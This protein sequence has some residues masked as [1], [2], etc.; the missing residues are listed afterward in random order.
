MK[1]L[2]KAFTLT[3]LFIG[4]TASADELVL[5]VRHAT[6]TQDY[7]AVLSHDGS[8]CVQI[9]PASSVQVRDSGVIIESPLL[10]Q[11][12][13]ILVPP[14]TPVEVTAYIGEL[15][16]GNYTVTWSQPEA[17]SLS[18]AME[19][20]W[21]PC[22]GCDSLTQAPYP[23]TGSWYN[24]DQ[25]GSGLVL[26]I[27]NGVLAGSYYGYDINGLPEWYL[28]NGP[29]V[30]SEQAG[31][32]WELET[33]LQSFK[34]GNCIGC[35]YM[36]PTGPEVGAAI[37]LEIQQRNFMR[38]TIGDNPSQYFVPIMYGSNGYAYFSEQTPYVFPEYGGGSSSLDTTYFM[39][40]TK[41]NTDPPSPWL[42]E[43]YIMPI[44][45]GRLSDQGKLTY[46]TFIPQGP[47]GPDVFPS[48]IECELDQTSYQPGCK[49]VLGPKE[50]VIPIGNLGD[51]R[52]YGEAEDGSTIE[53]YRL[54][55]D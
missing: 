33:N 16:P 49:W 20:S 24:P 23:E 53:G 27:Q 13:C 8:V 30:R 21:V 31:M 34:D 4:S 32:Q 42:W 5:T 38:V 51:S 12:P 29:M 26:E 54:N 47:P 35:E 44:T 40:V 17:F 46:Y 43:S 48:I 10:E 52:I 55:Y 11:L 41:P 15:A 19:T 37:K 39:F 50:Y 3:A 28:V 6:N 9:S 1:T 25:S 7:E 45:A 22:I 36:P 14:I 2:V 18:T